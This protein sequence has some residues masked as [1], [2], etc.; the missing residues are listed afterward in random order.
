MA[1]HDSGLHKRVEKLK[2]LPTFLREAADELHPITHLELI[3][4]LRRVANEIER[5][6][7]ED[8]PTS[9]GGLW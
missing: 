9:E 7:E 6:L 5:E 4:C 1:E 3:R 2:S 8:F